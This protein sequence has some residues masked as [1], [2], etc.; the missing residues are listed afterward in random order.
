MLLPVL[1][2]HAQPQPRAFAH[3]TIDDGLSSNVGVTIV[4][5]AQGFIW[6][7][8]DQGLNRYDGRRV[9]VFRHDPAD[10]TTLDFDNIMDL[11]VDARGRLWASTHSGVLHR[12]HP[13][14]E[15]FTRYPL[16][17]L[18][19]AATIVE[20]H[21]SQDGTLWLGSWE[22]G[23]WHFH[24]ERGVLAH[25]SSDPDDPATIGHLVVKE[26]LENPDGTL[27]LATYAGLNHF[28]PKTG[29]ATRY[30]IPSQPDRPE[31][32]YSNVAWE[33][34][35]DRTGALWVGTFGGLYRFVPE[36]ETFVAYLPE[37]GNPKVPSRHEVHRIIEDHEGHLWIGYDEGLD[38][39][40]PRTGVFE[41]M[42]HDV[43]I[44]TSLQMGYV[45]ALHQDRSGVLWVGTD[46]GGVSR[47][48]LVAQRIAFHPTYTADGTEAGLIEAVYEDR[49]GML[50]LGSESGVLRVD[51]ATGQVE[52]GTNA[53]YGV[54]S[55]ITAFWEDRGGTLWAAFY[56]KGV[57]RLRPSGVFDVIAFEDAYDN[58]VNVAV[59]SRKGGVW[60]GGYDGFFHW[61]PAT[62]THTPYRSAPASDTASGRRH[63]FVMALV[64]APDGTVWAGT[65]DGVRRLDPVTGH[66]TDY[67][68][69]ATDPASIQPGG[70][71]MLHQDASGSLWAAGPFGLSRLDDAATGRFT[72][73]VMAN[74]RLPTNT[75]HG[76]LEDADGALWLHTDLG[77]LRFD[78]ATGQV[79]N[80]EPH[81][82]GLPIDVSLGA[83]HRG[84]SGTLYF[85]TLDGYYAF[86]PTDL[87]PNAHAPAAVLTELRVADVIMQPQ[88]GEYLAEAIT[89]AQDLQLDYADRLFAIDFAALH[90]SQPEANTFA[91]R[92]EGF[93][94]D[95]RGPTSAASATYTNLDPGTYTFHVRA[96][97]S[98]GVW[99]EAA[100]LN[101][102]IA[103]PWWM[104][105]WFRLLAGLSGL[106]LL[107]ASYAW[108][109]RSMQRQKTELEYQVLV[110]T[111]KIDAQRLELE[112]QARQLQEMDAMK[113]A[114]FANTSHELRTPLTLI[115]GNL[116]DV[117]QSAEH[118]ITSEGQGHLDVAMTQTTRL[119][120]LVEQL[121]DLSRLQSKQMHLRAQYRNARTFVADIVTAFTAV[122]H[123]R[124]LALQMEPSNTPAWL[125]ADADKLEKIVTNL[126]G[127]AIKFTPSGGEVV[128]ALREA[129]VG[130]DGLGT[131]SFVVIEVRDTGEGISAEALPYIFDRF[132][133]ADGAVTR[134]REGMGVGLS[135]AQEL[136]AL[137]GGEIRCRSTQGEGATFQVFLPKGRDH[138]A[139]EEIIAPTVEAVSMTSPGLQMAFDDATPS[140]DGATGQAVPVD[141]EVGANAKT[142][143]VVEDNAE[144]RHYLTRHLGKHYRVLAAEDG[145]VGLQL[146]QQHRPD[147]IVS[148][149]MMPKL[150][151]LS[152]LRLLKDDPELALIPVLLLTARASTAAER[153]GLE[154]EAVHYIAKPFDMEDL[155]L[156]VAN[157]LKDRARVQ[158]RWQV[159]GGDGASQGD[160]AVSGDGAA[161][162]ERVSIPEIAGE[163]ADFLRRVDAYVEAHLQDNDLTVKTLAGGLFMGDRTFRR[164]LQETTGMTA[165]AYIRRVRLACAKRHLEQQHY[166]T[167]AEAAAAVGFSNASYFSRLYK[168]TYGVAASEVMVAK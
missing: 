157:V 14:T 88:H 74:G 114:F 75:I 39:F 85:G 135:L 104:T 100:L 105:L 148:D 99:G 127:N 8:T 1:L 95:W 19:G 70:I 6:I 57:G 118:Q 93:D 77:I 78:P 86:S 58:F 28:D 7:G 25:Y 15:S 59:P 20:I 137:H 130:G 153:E 37:P 154:A 98:D 150:D 102:A 29:R 159:L 4:Q 67:E 119:Q 163:D 117:I 51:Q 47:T 134:T 49:D 106:G 168:Q 79:S 41:R 17:R 155:L 27:W 83:F 68:H 55:Q 141:A 11:H 43:R 91:Y 60:L 138:L 32:S 81:V 136:A 16:P 156:R 38:R 52:H 90:Y 61:T 45:T 111:S 165:A 132:Y 44:P 82:V 13:E 5:D 129:T 124:G 128:V 42:Q 162:A 30:P 142:V 66:L 110:R 139:D 76:V 24:P 116:T 36:T 120:H 35:R 64:E 54:P 108:R 112:Q 94:P 56:G 73:Y 143:L 18:D 103:P 161:Q 101:V 92:L 3:L 115:R 166:A 69:D 71:R 9:K 133:Q 147:A 46:R 146:A 33:V 53:A 84:P 121:L 63:S 107:A 151:G 96:A 89:V 125:Y 123:Q 131:G 149:V 164:R 21:E 140:G 144:L 113:S 62:N 48:D 152:L 72:H 23:L 122:A 10:S 109:I 145:Q 34:H 26:V 31:T 40:D 2:V 12:Y 160:G 22:H 80:A 87:A 97:N 167:L 158:A 126:I 50:W 65:G